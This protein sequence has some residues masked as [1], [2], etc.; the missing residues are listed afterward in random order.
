MAGA[1][2]G[3][4]GRLCP[5]TGA[6]GTAVL[7]SPTPEAAC[8]APDDRDPLVR[9]GQLRG[10]K[11][12]HVENVRHVLPAAH[13]H[14]AGATGAA[15]AVMLSCL[16]NLFI[17]MLCMRNTG[18]ARLFGM[19]RRSALCERGDGRP[20]RGAPH[21]ALVVAQH[22]AEGWAGR[23]RPAGGGKKVARG[24]LLS[25]A[26]AAWARYSSLAAPRA[27]PGP[28]MPQGH[29]GTPLLCCPET[30]TR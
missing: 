17:A 8:S 12:H 16:S 11:L 24:V 29:P 26:A 21:A 25:S 27:V 1:F 10:S 15:R 6:A 22:E 5:P 13:V 20:A 4:Q 2:E 14:P 7:P 30:E 19:P 23:R 18:A 9:A 28:G 3:R